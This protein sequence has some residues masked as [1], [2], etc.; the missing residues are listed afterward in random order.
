M[1]EPLGHFEMQLRTDLNFGSAQTHVRAG[2]MSILPPDAPSTPGLAQ[3]KGRIR[4]E[5]ILGILSEQGKLAGTPPPEAAAEISMPRT[6]WLH[7]EAL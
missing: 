5:D 6:S 7:L 1:T 2:T 4:D 3:R